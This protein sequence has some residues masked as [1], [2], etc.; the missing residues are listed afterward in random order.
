MT[1]QFAV[2]ATHTVNRNL[3]CVLR[4]IQLVGR[5][6]VGARWRAADQKVLQ[7]FKNFKTKHGEKELPRQFWINFY[8]SVYAEYVKNEVGKY[9]LDPW[10]VKGLIRQESMYNSRSLSPAGARGLM[11]I[12]PK[13][14]KRLFEQTHP[15]QTFENDLLFEPDLNIQLGVRYLNNLN[16]KHK[17][18]G[19]YILITYN[20]GPKVLRAWLSRFR[21]IEDM[22]IFVESIPYPETRGYVKHVFRNHGIYKNLYPS[23]L[24]QIPSNKSF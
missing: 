18:N 2:S 24:A 8:P 20:A 3:D 14:G 6:G 16:R 13:T 17:G 10:L 11:Q 4:N 7:L 12:M 1:Q 5:V 22:D 9:D 23:Q 19:I 21:E 15:N